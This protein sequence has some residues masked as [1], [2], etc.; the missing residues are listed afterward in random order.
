MIKK[1]NTAAQKDNQIN[2]AALRQAQSDLI[3]LQSSDSLAE[4]IQQAI[5]YTD[6][7]DAVFLTIEDE[8]CKCSAKQVFLE[9]DTK[10]SFNLRI[11][12][13]MNAMS[14]QYYI[15]NSIMQNMVIVD[16][17]IEQG[18]AA[19]AK[20]LENTINR[21]I[22]KMAQGS[23]GGSVTIPLA[24][25]DVSC[26]MELLKEELQNYFDTPLTYPDGKQQSM[27]NYTFDDAKNTVTFA[28][29]PLGA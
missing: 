7:L 13:I 28:I 27:Y 14:L 11:N 3:R 15:K 24:E 8:L 5:D 18:T 2:L 10:C 23:K 16:L 21:Q 26:G 6:Q 17:I 29:N 12:T 20:K 1:N 9:N 4:V 25:F 19:N 22:Y